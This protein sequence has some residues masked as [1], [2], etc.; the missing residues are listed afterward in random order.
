[1]ST[2]INIADS[3]LHESSKDYHTK[4]GE[5]LSSHL[6]ADFRRCPDLYHRRRSG[7]IVDEDRPA[8]LVGRAAHTVILEGLEAFQ[9]SFAIGGPV[10]PKTGSP[11]GSSTKAWAT[12][13]AEQDRD[14][15]TNAQFDLVMKLFHAVGRHT[16]ASELLADG[17]AEC[18][19]REEYCGRK[20]QIRADWLN[21]TEGLVDLKTCDDLQWFEADARRYGYVHQMAFYRAVLAQ[22]I[23]ISVPVHFIAVEKKE[24]F[25]CG[26]WLV[27]EDSLAIAQQENEAAIRRLLRCEETYIWKTGYEEV[28]SLDCI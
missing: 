24:P 20:C 5:Y 25:R 14:V 4:A 7:L 18:V 1:M 15:L 27:S 13:A 12:W 17:I 9:E 11:Y 23:G 28:R 19:L 8:Y 22:V 21:P 6:L 3:L 2:T 16:K 10:N 26:L